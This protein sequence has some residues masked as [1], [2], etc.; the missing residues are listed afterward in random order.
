MLLITSV[1]AVLGVPL[2]S[3]ALWYAN[4]LAIVL[5]LEPLLS[6]HGFDRKAARLA[7]TLGHF[8]YCAALVLATTLIGILARLVLWILS[9]GSRSSNTDLTMAT[10]QRTSLGLVLPS[11]CLA[12]V[13]YRPPSSELVLRSRPLDS[14]FP[15]VL[16]WRCS[17]EMTLVSRC[18]VVVRYWSPLLELGSYERE[19]S[20]ST[21]VLWRAS[22]RTSLC[23]RLGPYQTTALE[24]VPFQHSWDVALWR[25]PPPAPI[26]PGKT[27]YAF[28]GPV[29]TESVVTFPIQPAIEPY[30]CKAL[31]RHGP[32]DIFSSA[33]ARMSAPERTC[34]LA[35]CRANQ[36]DNPAPF[37]IYKGSVLAP[38]HLRRSLIPVDDIVPFFR[39]KWISGGAQSDDELYSFES[40]ESEEE[41]L[42]TP[43]SSP[44]GP[45][46][47]TGFTCSSPADNGAGW[48]IAEIFEPLSMEL[49]LDLSFPP[50]D[51]NPPCDFISPHH[52]DSEPISEF[53]EGQ[54]FDA[55]NIDNSVDELCTLFESFS[56]RASPPMSATP[57][58]DTMSRQR[59][60][61]PILT[62]PI[63]AH[64]K[65]SADEECPLIAVDTRPTVLAHPPTLTKP[66]LK[67]RRRL[68]ISIEDLCS[69]FAN[70]SVKAKASTSLELLVAAFSQWNLHSP[71][72]TSPNHATPNHSTPPQAGLGI[73]SR[74]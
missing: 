13:L 36:T 24:L 4:M 58:L 2:A 1:L 73:F 34:L 48:S 61:T 74:I 39:N 72:P 49:D 29:Y 3:L 51:F 67:E 23:P 16:Y 50:F 17:L 63:P 69:E 21:L 55:P 11:N 66:K 71:N 31:V 52:H 25:D 46:P 68:P 14:T 27:I 42:L 47:D 7:S 19:V 10:Y 43:H 15:T 53:E 44:R 37:D 60:H 18:L 30:F 65:P 28:E 9:K 6:A 38:Y 8:L 54:Y 40:E 62:I 22:R 57:V 45:R 59:L 41:S 33:S 12:V 5:N 26:A 64:P 20:C 32:L 56:L 35:P 70:M